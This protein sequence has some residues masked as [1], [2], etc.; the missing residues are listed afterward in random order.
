MKNILSLAKTSLVV[1]TVLHLSSCSQLKE[2]NVVVAST[3]K[4]SEKVISEV[5]YPG[6]AGE[7]KKGTLF[8]QNITYTEIN[9]E[10]IWEG[11]IVLSKRQLGADTGAKTEG[12]GASL[13]S[14]RWENGIV[15]Y[16]ID[17]SVTNSSVI[18]SAM[19]LI[20]STV[21]VKFV[22]RSNQY[23]YVTFKLGRGYSSSV[24]V[25]GGQQ[26]LT[27]GLAYSKG[28]VL[29]EICHT[30]GLFHEHTRNDRDQTITVN[31]ANIPAS[32]QPNFL[33][34]NQ[35]GDAG[36]DFDKMD[37]GSVMMMDSYYCSGNNLPTMTTKSGQTF[38]IQRDNL[39]PN[40]IRCLTAMYSN[41]FSIAGRNLYAAST[42][43]GSK[44]LLTAGWG[45]T[46]AV[47]A[48]PYFF[49]AAQNGSLLRI[50]P[51]N[52]NQKVIAT[53]Y[54][55]VQAMVLLQGFLYVINDGTLIK[56]NTDTGASS[57]IGSK[58]WLP[59]TDIVYTDGFFYIMTL[60]GIF[61]VTPDTGIYSQICAV[62]DA[63]ELVALGGYLYYVKTTPGKTFGIYKLHPSNGLALL[64]SPS[65]TAAAQMVT[66]M[67]KKLYVADMGNLYRVE[68]NGSSTIVSSGWSST[69]QL[70]AYNFYNYY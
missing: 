51:L 55:A 45:S 41:I 9:Q 26:F 57:A 59:A 7:E 17:K 64:F 38:T 15:Y 22:Y 10:A 13:N 70:A 23:N 42:L 8:G 21:P 58:I 47:T 69:T 32:L 50:N 3:D 28:G 40:D 44:A 39:S 60:N 62:A 11:D 30:L 48:D 37:L 36:F 63:R 52:G 1:L 12:T 31:F 54:N 43:R 19:A 27:L 53:G 16:T 2:E 33:M 6:E 24:G 68:A 20:E 34:H 4:P 61:R 29:H 67:D 14:Q 35:S 25:T 49:Y 18:Y 66:S 5:A 65:F 56:V 46:R